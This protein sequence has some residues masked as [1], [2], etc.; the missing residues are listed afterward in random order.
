M[1]RN[2]EVASLA[3]KFRMVID[4]LSVVNHDAA[5]GLCTSIV[6]VC[7]SSACMYLCEHEGGWLKILT[8]G[9]RHRSDFLLAV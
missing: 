6:S 8:I 1:G 4:S 7:I 2:N 3:L 5:T 9:H